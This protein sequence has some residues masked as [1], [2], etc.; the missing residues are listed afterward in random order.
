MAYNTF[1]IVGKLGVGKETDKFK[2]FETKDNGKGWNSQRLTCYI[3]ND[4]NFCNLEISGGYSDKKPVVYSFTK[5]DGDKKGQSIEIPWNKRKDEEVINKIAEF[6]KNVIVL[7]ETERIETLSG[8]DFAEEVYNLI[9]SKEYKDCLW[10]VEGNVVTNEWNGKFY[11][12]YVPS[13]IYKV[14]DDAEHISEGVLE[15]HFGEGCIDDQYETMNKIF[16][17][18][19]TRE[20]DGTRKKEIGIPL[21][22]IEVS[23]ANVKP[24]LKEKVYNK[25]KELFTVE[26]EKFKKIGLRVNFLSGA[27]DIE[28]NEDML[29][30]EQKEMIE[31][32][33][34][35][36]DEIKK[37][38]GSG[39]SNY[40][41]VTRVAGLSRG[42]SKGAIETEFTLNDYLLDV[43]N[44]DMDDDIFDL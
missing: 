5:N 4:V 7:S 18:G 43:D 26:D 2:P 25:Y 11:T 20:Y 19:Y 24:E 42:Y 12:K 36:L 8:Y 30:E 1:T 6:R 17:K 41:N 15:F 21:E 29:D 31:L 35:T 27:Q 13:R 34:I 44:D 32:G 10:K 3:K 23:F 38:M 28:F 33:F 22:P 14:E 9:N 37:E 40:S 39:K 16:I